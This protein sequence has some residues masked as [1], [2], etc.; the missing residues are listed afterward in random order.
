MVLI[1]FETLLEH[2]KSS[3]DIPAGILTSQEGIHYSD[4]CFMLPCNTLKMQHIPSLTF[5]TWWKTMHSTCLST[6][7]RTP[8]APLLYSW[9]TPLM[10][11]NRYQVCQHRAHCP[12]SRQ[13]GVQAQVHPHLYQVCQ[14]QHEI[15]QKGTSQRRQHT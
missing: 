11:P 10:M 3:H 13:P 2:L 14:G 6:N 5:V 8:V 12:L 15:H 1:Q 4:I 7:Q 9:C